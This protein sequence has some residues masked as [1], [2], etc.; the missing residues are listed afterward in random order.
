MEGKNKLIYNSI[1]N[2]IIII[3]SNNNIILNQINEEINVDIIIKN[4]ENS[5]Y[6]FGNKNFDYKEFI[7]FLLYNISYIKNFHHFIS[8]NNE[9][10]TYYNGISKLYINQEDLWLYT[11]NDKSERLH[12]NYEIISTYFYLKYGKESTL[13]YWWEIVITICTCILK[14]HYN[15]YVFRITSDIKYGFKNSNNEF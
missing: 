8:N 5:V 7:D 15:W 2:D 1:I 9:I 11:F 13:G 14:K 10:K 12:L 3:D 6:N 4:V